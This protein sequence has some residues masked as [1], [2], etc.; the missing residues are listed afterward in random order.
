MFQIQAAV[1]LLCALVLIPAGVVLCVRAATRLQFSESRVIKL[2]AVGSA[3]ASFLIF[4]AKWHFE[5]F[6]GS[7]RW[8]PD[9]LPLDVYG[10]LVYVIIVSDFATLLIPIICALTCA[11]VIARRRSG[12]GDVLRWLSFGLALNFTAVVLVWM[13]VHQHGNVEKSGVGD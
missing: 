8:F 2:S 10:R 12:V 5:A 13:F 6:A 4:Y 9:Y 7:L 1:L 11:I 3:F